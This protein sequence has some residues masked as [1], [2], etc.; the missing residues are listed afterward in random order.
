VAEVPAVRLLLERASAAAPDFVLDAGNASAVAA[1]CRGLDGLPLALELAAPRLRAMSPAEIVDRL[2]ARFGLL[3]GGRSA[4]V[5]RHR[6]LRTVVDWSY[7]LLDCAE[8]HVFEQLSVFAGA[9]TLAAAEAVCSGGAAGQAIDLDVASVV[10]SLVDRSMV[11]ADPRPAPTRYSLLETLRAYGRDRLARGDPSAAHRAHAE[12]LVAVAE[13]ADV[14]V[15]GPDEGVQIDELARTVDDL[16]AA[17]RWALAHDLG[18]AA[19]LSAALVWFAKFHLPPE[20]PLWAEQVAEAAL[21]HPDRPVP[22]TPAVLAIAAAGARTRGDF[23]RAGELAERALASGRPD[24]PGL[25]YP[26]MVQSGLALFHGRLDEADRLADRAAQLARAAADPGWVVHAVVNRSVAA[27]YGGDLPRARELAAEAEAEARP[28]RNPTA[29]GWASYAAAEAVSAEDPDR[30]TELLTRSRAHAAAGRDR[31]LAGVA[32]VAL[33]ALH[34]R[35][36]DPAAALQLSADVIDHWHRAGNWTQQWTTLRNVVELLVRLG[37][38]DHAVVLDAAVESRATAAP[39]FGKAAERQQRARLAL[40]ARLGAAA[41]RDAADRAGAL[42]DDEVV[43]LARA[44][45][46]EV[47]AQRLPVTILT[48]TDSSSAVPTA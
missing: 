31:Y 5:G 19:R 42:L 16:R 29:L 46:A 28:T 32:L 33:A 4:A 14:A 35:H 2:D 47:A 10:A 44:T 21:R 45:I 3:A 23:A 1:L 37:A 26:L 6:T 11:T 13:A 17:H 22:R 39:A 36:G 38:D 25:R 8:R 18:L 24:D 12:Y 15:R 43:A 30:A 27:A 9:F 34:G 48:D 41:V 20:V 40:R 7:E